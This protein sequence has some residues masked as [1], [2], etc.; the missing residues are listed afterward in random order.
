MK[1]FKSLQELTIKDNF[2]FAATMLEPENCRL[3]LE[4]ILEIPIGHVDVNREKNLVYHPD[5]KGVRLDVYAND[6]HNTHFNVEM[7]VASEKLLKRARYYHSQIDLELLTTG[8]E[9][10]NLPN[11]YV[12]FICDFD[13][14]GSNKYRYTMRKT[15]S[16]D[17]SYY[18]DDGS[19]TVF[20][21]TKGTN[22]QEV[23][24]KI[25]TFLHFI[26]ANLSES[27]LDYNDTLI[28]R[29]QHTIAEIKASREMGAQYMSMYFI[30]QAD[31]RAGKAEGIAESI[32]DFLSVNY[33][34]PSELAEELL[35]N[36]NPTLLKELLLFAVK[37]NSLEA[38]Q[39]EFKRLSKKE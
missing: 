29:L 6:E 22:N 30:R 23:S 3:V 1:H 9:Y 13:P 18:Y 38:F 39:A 15:L 27:T 8:E 17:D 21:N 2:L 11:S 35:N 24:D 5:Y 37:T 10:T 26:G 19:Y 25:V 28:V 36:E 32:I 7:Q 34:V 16:E 4:R 20:L 33:E 31:Y 14:I 12:I